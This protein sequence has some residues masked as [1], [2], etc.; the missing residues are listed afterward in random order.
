MVSRFVFIIDMETTEEEE[1]DKLTAIPIERERM[2]D[3]EVPG[4]QAVS[5]PERTWND[6]RYRT[7]VIHTL[8]MHQRAGGSQMKKSGYIA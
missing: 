6:T 3:S 4:M 7:R 8:M 1:T 5:G 2:A